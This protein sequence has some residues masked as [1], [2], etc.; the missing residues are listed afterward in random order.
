ME[1]KIFKIVSYIFL[2]W[3]ISTG[4]ERLE[5]G[6]DFLSKPPELSYSLDSVWVSADRAREVLWN[7]YTTLPWG[8]PTFNGGGSPFPGNQGGMGPI[9]IWQLTDYY[10]TK[11]HFTYHLQGWIYGNFSAQYINNY[12]LSNKAF[13]ADKYGWL[14]DLAFDGAR[15]C[16][17]F[18]E[19]IDKVPDMDASEKALL[20]AEA[21]M[22]IATNFTHMF[23]HYGGI[24][25]PRPCGGFP[26]GTVNRNANS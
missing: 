9:P 11:V 8:L 16:Y 10:S 22:I 21:K 23:R 1:L 19:N 25:W 12:E 6:N 15:K 5:F 7:A 2:F 3:I 14:R 17:I 24:L 4:C 18:L 20:K 26:F 13:G